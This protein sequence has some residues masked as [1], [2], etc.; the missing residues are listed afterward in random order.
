MSTI[1]PLFPLQLVAFPGEALNLHIFE[2]RYRQLI[3]ECETDGIT[4]G[5][6]AFI[7]GRVQEIG[8]EIELIAIEK[9]YGDGKLDVKTKGIGIFKIEEFLSRA[10]SKLYP[11]A[12]VKK[13]ED[14]S[15]GDIL[16][17]NKI[18]EKNRRTV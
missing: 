2:P 12:K 15:H 7:D 8:T 13:I 9:R 11:G 18:V 3:Q 5:I 6:P 4:F 16:Q 14:D 10:P 17:S 1:L